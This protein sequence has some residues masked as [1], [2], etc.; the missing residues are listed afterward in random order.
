MKGENDAFF[1]LG[2]IFVRINCCLVV[3][4]GNG[5]AKICWRLAFLERGV[6]CM[7]SFT[8]TRGFSVF[9]ARAGN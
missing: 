6:Q 4:F 9:V 7:G 1:F 5:C 2:G 8:G 3:I